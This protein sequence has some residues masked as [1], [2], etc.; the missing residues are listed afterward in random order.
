MAIDLSLLDILREVL[1]N[2]SGTFERGSRTNCLR[3]KR[4]AIGSG[5]D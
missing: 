5:S 2:L 3:N 1:T 4:L